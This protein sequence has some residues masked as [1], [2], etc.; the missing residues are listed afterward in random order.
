MILPPI[1]ADIPMSDADDFDGAAPNCDKCLVP[2]DARATPRG[3]RWE[4]RECGAVKL[5]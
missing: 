1:D 5:S 4:C 2:M 3:E